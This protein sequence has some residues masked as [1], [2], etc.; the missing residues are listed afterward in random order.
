MLSPAGGHMSHQYRCTRGL[1][2]DQ[3]GLEGGDS[4]IVLRHGRE[5]SLPNRWPSIVTWGNESGDRRQIA[6]LFQFVLSARPPLTRGNEVV[7]NCPFGLCI[8]GRR[9]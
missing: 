1:S 4:G 2:V 8:K 7:A 6:V 5:L 9:S 3:R